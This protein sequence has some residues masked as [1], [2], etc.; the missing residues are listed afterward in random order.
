[1]CERSELTGNECRS[2]VTLRGLELP[3]WRQVDGHH[4]DASGCGR[5]MKR[6]GASTPTPNS[7]LSPP[8]GRLGR[9]HERPVVSTLLSKFTDG[10]SPVTTATACAVAAEAWD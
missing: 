2:R 5:G 1:M 8:S 10:V 6:S 3:R 4:A 7:V 9:V